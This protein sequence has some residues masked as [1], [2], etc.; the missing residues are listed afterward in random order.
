MCCTKL[1]PQTLKSSEWTSLYLEKTDLLLHKKLKFT[2]INVALLIGSHFI[3]L[4]RALHHFD[5]FPPTPTLPLTLIQVSLTHCY[6]S[7]LTC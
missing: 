6:L 3:D 4:N 1:H 2:P 5:S 7:E